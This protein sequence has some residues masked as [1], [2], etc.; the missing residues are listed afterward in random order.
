MSDA[1]TAA[2]RE[3]GERLHAIEQRLAALEANQIALIRA[4]MDPGTQPEPE[5]EPTP[6]SCRFCGGR[7]RNCPRCAQRRR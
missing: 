4:L 1:A 5:P 7:A 2:L 3:V 6:P